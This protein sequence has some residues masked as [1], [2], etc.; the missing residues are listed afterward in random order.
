MP[1][2]GTL[3]PCFG[4]KSFD[5]VAWEGLS[6]QSRAGKGVVAKVVQGKELSGLPE[7]KVKEP[8]YDPGLF[9]D[10]VLSV[11]DWVELIGNVDVVRFYGVKWFWGLTRLAGVAALP[12]EGQ[13]RA[14]TRTVELVVGKVRTVVAN[15][16]L[17]DPSL[18]SG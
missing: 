17:R 12:L 2:R 13:E 18:R 10:S 1:E 4:V 14:T 8:Q 6:L 16:D 15:Q 11:A 9:F 7:F 3:P 5:S